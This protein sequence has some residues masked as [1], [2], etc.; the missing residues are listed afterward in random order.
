VI[1]AADA[2]VNII[3]QPIA[4][5]DGLI[6]HDMKPLDFCGDSTKSSAPVESFP[7][8]SMAMVPD[9]KWFIKG[10]AGLS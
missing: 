5:G 4:E 10:R 2:V 9:E 1:D 8:S 7:C 6:V 3:P